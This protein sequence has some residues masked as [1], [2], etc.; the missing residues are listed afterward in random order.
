[1]KAI[2]VTYCSF[3]ESFV[4]KLKKQLEDNFQCKVFAFKES[5]KYGDEWFGEIGN[6]LDQ[7]KLHIIVLSPVSINKPWIYFEAGGTW[8]KKGA[9]PIPMRL[10]LSES[11]ICE[12]SPL[13]KLWH[14]DFFKKG[15]IMKLYEEIKKR[16]PLRRGEKA[17]KDIF[18]NG[19][20]E[21]LGD[22]YKILNA[23][24]KFKEVDKALHKMAI[25]PVPAI[26]RGAFGESWN[27][28]MGIRVSE[29]TGRITSW[30]PPRV[31]E[32]KLVFDELEAHGLIRQVETPL[33]R[34]LAKIIKKAEQ[35]STSPLEVPDKVMS[36]LFPHEQM[37]KPELKNRLQLDY[38]ADTDEIIA[39]LHRGAGYLEGSPMI[40]TVISVTNEW[41]SEYADE[42]AFSLFRIGTGKLVFP[43]IYEAS[44]EAGSELW[45]LLV[46][47]YQAVV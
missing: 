19:I 45:R 11:A 46:S 2:F 24:A 47:W 1:M 14:G 41:F 23:F 25:A 34:L 44:F 40:D 9:Q 4:K 18:V 15:D 8:I 37:K 12:Q 27:E 6:K 38:V 20:I 29:G 10:C 32:V 35:G 16:I 36:A 3:E 31:A 33:Q 30:S 22:K 43:P 17:T 26:L 21:A 39:R 5:L 42:G 7:S 28:G 13:S